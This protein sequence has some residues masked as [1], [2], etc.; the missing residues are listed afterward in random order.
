MRAELRGPTLRKP[1]LHRD[2]ASLAAAGG[3]VA[4]VFDPKD[5]AEGVE[6]VGDD[7]VVGPLAALVASE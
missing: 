2:G 4:L 1:I 6:G 5:L 3:T 7:G